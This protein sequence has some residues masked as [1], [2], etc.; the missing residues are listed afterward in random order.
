MPVKQ[1]SRNAIVEAARDLIYHQGYGG[2]SYAD[3]SKRTGL[4][5]GN[6]H[7]HFNSKDEILNAVAENRT[8][9]IRRLMEGW[10]LD[11]STPYD[12]LE[13]F[14]TMFEQNAEDLSHFGC[15]IGTL[16]DELGKAHPELQESAREMFDLFIRWL[17]ARFRAILPDDLAKMHA[18]H[19]LIMAQGISVV[20]HSYRD[21]EI[22]YRHGRALREWLADVCHRK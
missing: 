10:T 8:E 16:N 9:A 13:R 22:V 5:K 21:P 14:I 20:A 11:C 2:T 4:G 3:I 18:E 1:P 6:I 7:Y 15:P 12:C 19:L 17:E